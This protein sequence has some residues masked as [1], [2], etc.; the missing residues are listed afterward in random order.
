MTPSTFARGLGAL[1]LTAAAAATVTASPAQA[2]TGAASADTVR[3]A[4]TK[5]C[6]K[7]DYIFPCGHWT[8]TMRSGKTI[9]LTDARTRPVNKKGKVDKES[10]T[11]FAVSG[12]GRVVNYFK[13]DKLVVRDVNTGEVRPLPGAAAV[14][15]K[16]LGMDNLDTTLSP[17]G[18]IVV[19]D[20]FDEKDRL[21][22][23]VANVKTGKVIKLSA[24]YAVLSFS[25]DGEHLLTSRY[26]DD[27]TTEFAVFDAAGEKTASQVVPQIVSNNA[28]IA[29]ADDG[30]TVALVITGGSGKTS[31]RTYDLAADTVSEAVPLGIPK[32]ESSQRLFW[33]PSGI[34]TLWT[35]LLDEEGDVTAA[36]KRTVD[37][38]SGTTRTLDSFKIKGSPWSWWLPGE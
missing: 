5:S 18:S 24:K 1:T 28:P 12:D 25:P 23:M 22:S 11:T 13:G 2:N 9:K 29:L 6:Q 21:P 27:N 34:L 30:N 14:L 8:L 15:P 10:I 17:D 4:W 3:Y 35:A 7:K 37:A 32:K 16:G 19:V 38:G 31:L 26:T 33:N 20:Y 36:V